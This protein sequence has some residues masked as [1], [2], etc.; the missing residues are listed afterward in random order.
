MLWIVN[1]LAIQVLSCVWLFVTPWT[2][3]CQ[4]FPICHQILELAQTHVHQVGDAIQPSHPS[5]PPA[6][7]FSQHQGFFPMSHFN[8]SG[9][10]SIGVS[11]SVL[12]FNI[13]DWFPLNG[14]VGS[15]CT[16]KDS[17][18]S[19]PIP[20]FKSI[21]SSVLSFVYSPTLQSIQDYWKK[22]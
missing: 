21:N 3:T 18:G 4:G 6:F 11:S 13:Q 14:R 20:Q 7:N 8:A 10:Q 2:A 15:P 22:P 12:P 19:P 17:R 5:S 16:P 9:G 1:Y